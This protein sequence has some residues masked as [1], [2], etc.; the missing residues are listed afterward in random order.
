MYNARK[1]EKSVTRPP[2]TLLLQKWSNGDRAAFDELTDY[3]YDDLHRRAAAYIRNERGDHSLAAT[4]LVHEAFIKLVEKEEIEF[5]DRNH[6]FAIA[7]KT[8]RRILV[9]HARS[10]KRAKRGGDAVEIPLEAATLAA[11]PAAD[12][13][14]EELNNALDELSTFDQQQ[15]RLVELKYFAGMTLD[16]T[17]EVLSVSRE[18]VKREWQLARAWLRNRLTR[19]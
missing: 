19:T 14:L 12:I 2:I 17:A 16:E 9:D 3:V 13:D 6:F 15:A 4:G 5:A 10:K 11:G 1:V 7:A 8:M 18:T